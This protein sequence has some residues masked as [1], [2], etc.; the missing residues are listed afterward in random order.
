MSYKNIFKKKKHRYSA[1]LIGS[2]LLF[3]FYFSFWY[4]FNLGIAFLILGSI[5]IALPINIYRFKYW[6]CPKCNAFLG[7]S[8]NIENCMNCNCALAEDKKLIFE[9]PQIISEASLIDNNVIKSKTPAR[10][11][12][13]DYDNYHVYN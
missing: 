3:L 8:I 11:T 4:E 5:V 10:S 6:R 12:V 9:K 2:I 1:L 7:N 13:H